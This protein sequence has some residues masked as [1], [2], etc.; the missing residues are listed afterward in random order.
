[1][2]KRVSNSKECEESGNITPEGQ[3]AKR[4]VGGWGVTISPVGTRHPS[5]VGQGWKSTEIWLRRI[6]PHGSSLA[7]AKLGGGRGEPRG[8]N[9]IW[10]TPLRVQIHIR[11]HKTFT[12]TNQDFLDLAWPNRVGLRIKVVVV[13]MKTLVSLR[14]I[15]S[16]LEISLLLLNPESSWLSSAGRLSRALKP[17]FSYV[18]LTILPHLCDAISSSGRIPC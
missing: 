6:Q 15:M 11:P 14:G 18:S 1:M 17:I 7:S 8:K 12:G 3:K 10:K 9:T 5:P 4:Q 13:L 2:E 16:L